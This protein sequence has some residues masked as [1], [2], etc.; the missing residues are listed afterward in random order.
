MESEPNPEKTI[1]QFK[2]SLEIVKSSNIFQADYINASRFVIFGDQNIIYGENNVRPMNDNEFDYHDFTLGVRTDFIAL[3]NYDD[4]EK[5]T[6]E[7]VDDRHFIASYFLS[8]RP[9]YEE[10][11]AHEI[12]HNIFDINYKQRFGE[13]E[14]K[15]GIPEISDDYRDKIKYH[16][17][18]LTKKYYP[19]LAIEK[20]SFNRQQISEIFAMIYQRQFCE[21]TGINSNTN[22][23]VENNVQSFVNDP[24]GELQKF[25]S[26]HNRQCSIDDFYSENHILS[27][28]VSN[29]IDKEYDDFNNRLALF[30]Q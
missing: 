22:T 17:T 11:I 14:I 24:T 19:T 20:F 21:N 15:N 13:Y 23:L 12:A 7:N 26:L 27:L 9:T 16:I 1:N 25:N 29:L 10:F 18:E 3:N 28:I 8:E 2:N 6:M 4:Y 30:W 5:F